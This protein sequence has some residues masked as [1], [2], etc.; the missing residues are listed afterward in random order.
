MGAQPAVTS[1]AKRR[2]LRRLAR[3]LRRRVSSSTAAPTGT[4]TETRSRPRVVECAADLGVPGVYDQEISLRHLDPR[5]GDL[6]SDAALVYLCLLVKSGFWP[7]VEFGTFRGRTTCNLALN[8]PPGATLYSIDIGRPTDEE[9]NVEGRG[10]GA[11]TAGELVLQSEPV[12]RDKV[13]MIQADSTTLELSQLFG[14]VGL[15]IVD[16]GH[17]YE[18]CKHDSEHA[19][20]L[21]RDGGIV[22]WDDYSGYWPGVKRC[23]DELA[24]TTELTFV[25]REGL[26][27]HIASTI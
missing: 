22:V 7:V 12:L 11:Y 23:L 24:A 20:K 4:A 16:G 25:K 1:L 2:R 21:V 10:Y 5:W 9:S 27:V 19:L 13:T 15:V 8:A 14:R 17:S 26:V 6:A 3:R 18:V